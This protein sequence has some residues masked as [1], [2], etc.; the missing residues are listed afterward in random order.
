M[1]LVVPGRLTPQGTHCL[2]W[3]RAN[4]LTNENSPNSTFVV[5]ALAAS[6]LPLPEFHTVSTEVP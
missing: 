1:S 3:R 6:Y 4:T 2:M 5:S